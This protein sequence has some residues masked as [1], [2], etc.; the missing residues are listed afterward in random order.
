L[1]GQSALLASVELRATL[2]SSSYVSLGLFPLNLNKIGLLAYTDFALP[3]SGFFP[4]DGSGYRLSAGLYLT[5]ELG[6]LYQMLFMDLNFIIH[7]TVGETAPS[8]AFAMDFPK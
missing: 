7:Y 8:F 6:F 3:F 4:G 1:P 5:V 2:F